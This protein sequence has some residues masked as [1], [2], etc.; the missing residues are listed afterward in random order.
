MSKGDGYD[1][2]DL[3]D[4]SGRGCL[5]ELVLGS[6]G[7]ESWPWIPFAMGQR[8]L[9]FSSQHLLFMQCMQEVKENISEKTIASIGSQWRDTLHLSPSASLSLSSTL[10]NKT[11]AHAPHFLNIAHMCTCLTQN[12]GWFMLHP[13]V[14]VVKAQHI[15]AKRI[16]E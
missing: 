14:C 15:T 9:S 2:H 7:R 4:G 12:V 8:S 6:V 11:V 16:I 10:A 3:H 5:W 13:F 1:F